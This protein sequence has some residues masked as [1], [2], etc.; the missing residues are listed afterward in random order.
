MI[1]RTTSGDDS[2]DSQSLVSYVVNGRVAIDAGALGLMNLEDQRAINHVVLTHSHADHVATLPVFVEIA[3]QT[4]RQITV[5]GSEHTLEALRRHMFNDIIWPD[6]VEREPLVKLVPLV[7]EVPMRIESLDIIPIPV[8]HSVP[9]F[10][11]VVAEK[12][13]SVVFTSDT[14]PTE[15]IWEVAAHADVQAVF[16]EASFPNEIEA[17]A[18]KTGHYTPHLLDQDLTKFGID[19]QVI[20]AQIKPCHRTQVTKELRC[21]WPKQFI[22]GIQ[23]ARILFRRPG[24]AKYLVTW[25]PQSLA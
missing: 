2:S 9:T 4:N 11:Y 17:W 13:C 23:R 10:G 18:I 1:V 3:L 19:G 20:C 24:Y 8:N 16:T 14:G 7:A 12:R 5:Y 22:S 6:L 25:T 15:R 21:A